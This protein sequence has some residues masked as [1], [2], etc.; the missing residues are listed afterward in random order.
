[1]GTHICTF[2]GILYIPS[3]REGTL[4]GM[5]TLTF[6]FQYSGT[7][8]E[9]SNIILSSTSTSTLLLLLPSPGS[10]YLTRASLSLFMLYHLTNAS[11]NYIYH[12]VQTN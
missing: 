10:W 3:D 1:M 4:P 9:T 11:N 8:Y 12:F 7:Q 2:E 6:N 5:H